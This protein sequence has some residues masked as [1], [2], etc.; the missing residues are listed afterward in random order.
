MGIQII[1]VTNTHNPCPMERSM[2]HQRMSLIHASNACN[3]RSFWLP[4]SPRRSAP[5]LPPQ[6]T[7]LNC[8][9]FRWWYSMLP[10]CT[11]TYTPY[12]YIHTHTPPQTN[13][14]CMSDP[15]P[16]FATLLI[17]FL[18]WFGTYNPVPCLSVSIQLCVFIFLETICIYVSPLVWYHYSSYYTL[19]SGIIIKK[20]TELPANIYIEGELLVITNKAPAII[21]TTNGCFSWDIKRIQDHIYT[22]LSVH[23]L[24]NGSI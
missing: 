8:F 11:I 14:A 2:S 5:H 24:A 12:I 21:S 16:H 17:V 6:H 20:I 15:H 18:I 19:Y 13:P 3:Q 9:F 23:S 4:R 7:L 1:P 10:S 22:T